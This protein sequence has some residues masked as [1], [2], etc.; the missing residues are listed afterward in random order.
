MESRRIPEHLSL[1]FWDFVADIGKGRRRLWTDAEREYLRQHYATTPT[2]EIAAALGR[3]VDLIIA[4]ANC[5]GLYKA[6][7]GSRCQH[8]TTDQAAQPA[9]VGGRG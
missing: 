8:N 3:P 9:R 7:R 5:M 4:R 2:R 6:G 1:A